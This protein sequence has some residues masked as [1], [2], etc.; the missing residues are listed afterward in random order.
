[1]DGWSMQRAA[2]AAKQ[3]GWPHLDTL[4][5]QTVWR[6][7]AKH[8]RTLEAF[9]RTSLGRALCAFSRLFEHKTA[10]EPL[11]LLWALVGLE[12]LYVQGKAEVAQ[13]VREKSQVLLGKQVAFK[14]KIT[15]MYDFRSR[16]VHG[17]LDF[18]GLCLIGDARETIANFD[19]ELLDAVG[20]AVAVLAGTIQEIIRRDWAGLHFD[21]SVADSAEAAT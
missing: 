6:W 7:A 18:P 16:F 4:E 21:Y 9:D 19:N 10:D 5:I 2:D 15:Q 20:M 11:Q 12:A 3:M 14:K 1:M 8:H 13:Q 17:D